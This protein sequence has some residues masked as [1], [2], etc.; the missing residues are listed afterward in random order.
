MM[1]WGDTIQ[2]WGGGSGEGGR[3]GM[4]DRL[5]WDERQGGDQMG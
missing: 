1:I 2:G 3:D 5:K 4:R